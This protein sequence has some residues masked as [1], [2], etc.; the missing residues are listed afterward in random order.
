MLNAFIA[1]R[2][3]YFSIYKSPATCMEWLH[4]IEFISLYRIDWA[5]ETDKIDLTERK[6]SGIVISLVI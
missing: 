1:A 2:D 4:G 5:S 6:C 3:T